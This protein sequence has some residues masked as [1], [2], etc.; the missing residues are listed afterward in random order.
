MPS[1][2]P[3]ACGAARRRSLLVSTVPRLKP[4]VPEQVL[5]AWPEPRPDPVPTS[6]LAEPVLGRWA[7]GARPPGPRS[8]RPKPLV[9]SLTPKSSETRQGMLPS[10]LP[11]LYRRSY[12]TPQPPQQRAHRGRRTRPTLRGSGARPPLGP[13]RTQFDPLRGRAPRPSPPHRLGSRHPLRATRHPVGRARGAAVLVLYP[14]R[15]SAGEGWLVSRGLLARL[16]RTD[17]LVSVRCLDGVGAAA[18]AAGHVRRSRR[19]GPPGSWWPIRPCGTASTRTHAC[20]PCAPR[21]RAGRP[22]CTASRSGSSRDGADGLQ[23]VRA[24][25][26]NRGQPLTE[27]PGVTSP[28]S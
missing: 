17:H 14:T 20:P 27:P 23:G 12:G 6:T 13:G 24:G 3:R 10:G 8:G 15:V 16:V 9:A 11:G 1:P 25:V 2:Y 7:A 19:D 21:S 28:V 26:R 22:R 4:L 5:L 18:R